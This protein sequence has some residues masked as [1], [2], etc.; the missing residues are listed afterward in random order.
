MIKFCKKC[1]MPD[2]RP[3]IVF[4]NEGVCNA[5]L[6]SEEKKKIDWE[7]R[8]REFLKL[9]N[10]IA[11]FTKQKNSKYSCIVPWSGGKDSTS[12]ALKLK[13]E[14]DLNPLLVTFSPLIENEIGVHNRNEL[15][16]MGFDSVM[17]KPN[18]KISRKLARRFFIERGNPKVAWDAGVNSAPLTVA[19]NYQIPYVFYA[20]HGES[21]YGGLVLDDES[22]KKRNIREVIEHQ[23]G[24][25]P[26]NWV[27]NEI[28]ENDLA[29]YIYPDENELKK[30]NITAYYF[31]YFFKWSM[32][33]NFH[34]VEKTM[35]KKFKTH[36]NKRT[37]G[38]FTDFDSLD[39]KIDCL[40]YYMQ[41]VKFGFG[42]ATRDACRMLQNDQMTR[43]K[44]IELAREYDNEFPEE[45]FKEVLE[46]LEM[47]EDEFELIVNQHRNNEIWKTSI[48]NKWKL[49]NSI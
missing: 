13:L 1:I 33:E 3:R 23:I 40:Y 37:Q 47:N 9:I 12:I 42:R 39:D 27:S 15:S 6:Y 41:Y 10:E 26:Q 24:D 35:K 43:Q 17:I 14:Y 22:Q 5:C 34:Y 44:A 31:S 29:P 7:D 21:E 46:F 4:N 30:T 20:E 18:L 49:I 2:S 36:P 25:F 45:N 16:K 8:K 28:R 48:D 19:L 11:E 32:L 38:T